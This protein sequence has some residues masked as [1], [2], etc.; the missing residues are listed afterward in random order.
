MHAPKGEQ[1]ATY[2]SI[3]RLLFLISLLV[4]AVGECSGTLASLVRFGF[5]GRWWR[6]N[7]TL[8]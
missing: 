3:V 2:L 1:D 4:L 5:W 6:L 7:L 8:F